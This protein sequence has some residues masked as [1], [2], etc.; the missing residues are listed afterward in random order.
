MLN[1][2]KNPLLKLFGFLLKLKF[3]FY[4]FVF[5][6]DVDTDDAGNPPFA[7]ITT[8]QIGIW[9]KTFR[10]SQDFYVIL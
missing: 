9:T 10:A 6:Q 3:L 4:Y 1:P 2:I 8:F 7:A 5:R